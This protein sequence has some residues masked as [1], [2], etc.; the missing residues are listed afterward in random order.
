MHSLNGIN[1]GILHGSCSI[2]GSTRTSLWH[3]LQLA[4]Q[5]RTGKSTKLDTIASGKVPKCASYK[6]EPR[7]T[8]PHPLV[9]N[10]R[11]FWAQSDPFWSLCE[12]RTGWHFVSECS[13]LTD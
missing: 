2:C 7:I 11:L 3:R 12:I 9:R 8:C 13:R 4:R 5:I 1:R 6:G 10:H